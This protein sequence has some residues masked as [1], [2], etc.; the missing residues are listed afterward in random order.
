MKPVKYYTQNDYSYPS[1]GD[2]TYHNVYKNGEVILRN[3]EFFQ[4]EDAIESGVIQLNGVVKSGNDFV[5]AALKNNGYLIENVVNM[6][7]FLDHKEKYQDCEQRKMDEF[8]HDLYEE[9]EVTD[10]PKVHKVY[11][12][13][14]EYGHSSGLSSVYNYF[15]ELVDLIK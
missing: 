3:A 13:A 9:F 5:I 14:W 15:S 7:S 6:Q 12:L 4:I 1:K 11:E 10:N 2:Y 8:I